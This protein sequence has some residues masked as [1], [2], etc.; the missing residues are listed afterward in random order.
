MIESTAV[1][2]LQLIPKKIYTENV[3][4]IDIILK[5][6]Y[7]CIK[8]TK[9]NRMVTNLKKVCGEK[10]IDFGYRFGVIDLSNN[11]FLLKILYLRNG[12]IIIDWNTF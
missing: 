2:G 4:C 1:C 5:C 9:L 7:L 3:Y 8:L 6:D 11:A 10:L 12:S